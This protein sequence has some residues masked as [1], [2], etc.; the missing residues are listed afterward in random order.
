MTGMERVSPINMS[1]LVGCFG[2]G[3]VDAWKRSH[4]PHS[5]LSEILSGKDTR[6]S[7]PVYPIAIDASR[8]LSFINTS[9]NYRLLKVAGDKSVPMRAK[10][11]RLRRESEQARRAS[12]C[13]LKPDLNPRLLAPIQHSASRP[14]WAHAGIVYNA[15]RLRG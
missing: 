5:D 2:R 1:R 6:A 10:F 13:T 12:S 9:F 15:I 7:L 3:V 11:C 8:R 14:L 4:F